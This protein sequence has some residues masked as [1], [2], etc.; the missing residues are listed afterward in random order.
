MMRKVVNEMLLSELGIK[1]EFETVTNDFKRFL[2]DGEKSLEWLKTVAAFANTKGGTLYVGVSDE[3]YMPIGL[4]KKTVDSQTQ[5]F[6]RLIKDH[7][8]PE[9]FVKVRYLNVNDETF[10]IEFSIAS[11]LSKPVICSYG[12]NGSIF[13]RAEGK[14]RLATTEEIQRMALDTAYVEY[15]RVYS[16]VEFSPEKFKILYST[17]KANTGKDLTEKDLFSIGFFDQER[18]CRRAALLFGDDFEGDET[19]LCVTDFM[20]LDKGG[21]RFSSEP[22]FRG[23]VLEGIKRVQNFAKEHSKEVYLKL[24]EKGYQTSSFPERA[25]TE[26]IVNAYAHRNYLLP[27]SQIEVNLFIDRLEIISPG[28]IVGRSGFEKRKDLGSLV[29]MRRNPFICEAL[30][31]LLLMERRGSGFDKIEKEYEVFSSSFKPFASSD[32]LSF[33]ITLPNLSYPFGVADKDNANLDLVFPMGDGEKETTGKIL[34]YCYF[35]K[36]PL[37]EIASFLDVTV[38]SYLRNNV[39]QRLVNRGLLMVEKQGNKDYYSTNKAF[40]HIRGENK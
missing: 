24:G 26:A 36:K 4:D 13:V 10:V 18:T 37:S 20:G 32:E 21:D 1:E 22:L 39:L 29:P 30:S 40:V 38:S 5:L 6:F 33:S 3:G 23:N 27:H 9:P 28:S 25:V 2:N 8:R 7:L 12:G 34:S 16:N 15:D 19:T 35:Q 17:Y 31:V 11:S 14:T